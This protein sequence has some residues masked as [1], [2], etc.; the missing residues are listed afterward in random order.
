MPEKLETGPQTDVVV[1]EYK[2]DE[3]GLDVPADKVRWSKK[4]EALCPRCEWPLDKVK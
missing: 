1:A 3:C 2:C 4:G